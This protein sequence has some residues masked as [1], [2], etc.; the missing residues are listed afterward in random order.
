MKKHAA[1][2]AFQLALVV[3][4]LRSALVEREVLEQKLSSLDR[5]VATDRYT[6]AVDD[7]ICALDRL[8]LLG[9]L[10]YMQGHLS[11]LA[12]QEGAA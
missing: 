12:T 3:S 8:R 4:R 10:A 9:T 6:A 5:D 7:I 11:R 2:P 1:D